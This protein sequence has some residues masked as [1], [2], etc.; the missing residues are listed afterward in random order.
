MKW[1]MLF[2][3][4]IFVPSVFAGGGWYYAG[5]TFT[6]D[7]IL[8]SVDGSDYDKVL[9][10]AGKTSY[11]I[12]LGE[13]VK[14]AFAEY[15][16]SD[17]AYPDDES[18]VKYASGH[19][20][21]AYSITINTFTPEI[22]VT[23]TASVAT[24]EFGKD[25]TFTVKI[26]NEGDFSVENVSYFEAIPEGLRV[27]SGPTNVNGSISYKLKALPIRKLD[28]FEYTI[29]AVDY[30]STSL[31]P[32]FAYFYA[33]KEFTVT[34]PAYSF[35]IDTP[36]EVTHTLSSSTLNLGEEGTYTFTIKNKD[37]TEDLLVKATTK[38]PEGFKR[39]EVQGLAP[40]DN[41]KYTLEKTFTPGEEATYSL[42]YTTEYSGNSEIPLDIFSTINGF[43]FEKHYVDT[44]TAK[45][46]K[47]N[48]DIKFSS[49]RSSFRGGEKLTIQATL[50]NVNKITTF[51]NINGYLNSPDLFE[52]VNFEHESFPPEK[53]FTEIEKAVVF[54]LA[55]ETKN[56]R[57]LFKGEY[58]TPSGEIYTYATEKSVTVDPVKEEVQITTTF[59]PEHP[60]KGKNVTVNVNIKN[61]FGEYIS[62]SAHDSF[63]IDLIKIGGINFA[64]GSLER[65]QGAALYTYQLE[66]PEN[67]TESEINLTT[68]VL[69]KGDP[70]P[71][72]FIKTIT[73]TGVETQQQEQTNVTTQNTTAT[74]TTD[75]V[76]EEN[77]Q[78]FFTKL[79][80]TI[81]GWFE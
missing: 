26:E 12:P 31:T 36:L 20:Y 16:Y 54:P 41:N 52:N 34:I 65:D 29:K 45:A 37:S 55:N 17:T 70:S 2:V 35:I 73:F 13:C 44:I 61:V 59:T 77:K 60:E 56:Y 7:G 33:G 46:D 79:W 50:E 58:A 3:T 81:K 10:G 49:T 80:S 75:G 5:D 63:D 18:K 39:K 68:S 66:I 25:V 74:Q 32:S 42:T 8:Y 6:E 28:Q 9:F 76:D 69:V 48:P 67:Y 21:Y 24:P 1:W 43:S 14:T 78:G 71:F 23:R 47:L 57:F 64:E 11:I 19:K 40:A 72:K 51:K 53:K 38:L 4:L 22:I 27:L 62:Y 30:A 15:C